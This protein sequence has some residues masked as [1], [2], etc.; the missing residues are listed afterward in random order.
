MP[1]FSVVNLVPFIDY[2]VAND[3][4]CEDKPSAKMFELACRKLS[5]S[6]KD[7]VMI[8]DNFKKDVQG[9]EKIGIKSYHVILE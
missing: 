3:E 5:L 1:L 9:A 2:I 6:A 4:A 7:V 8:G